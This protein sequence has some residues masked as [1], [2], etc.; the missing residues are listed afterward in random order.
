MNNPEPND[1]VPDSRPQ[2]PPATP[3]APPPPAV[4][5][6]P[7]AVPP[8]APAGDSDKHRL[9]KAEVAAAF[10]VSRRTVTNWLGRG[11]PSVR[12]PDGRRLFD[13]DEVRAWRLAQVGDDG[14]EDGEAAPASAASPARASLAKADLV[15]KVTQAK[16]S[17][18]EL[19]AEQA[20]KDLGL[21]TKILAAKTYEDYV[22]IDLEIGAL[23]ARGALS[24]ARARAIQAVI[25]DARQN[26]KA[27]REAEGDEEPQRL[28]LLTSEGAELVRAFEGICSDERRQGILDYVHA[29]AE[30]DLAEYPNVD[31]TR[32]AREEEGDPGQ[33][34]GEAGGA[35]PTRGP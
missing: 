8:P 13:R 10:G 30:V 11:C 6:P 15:R 24:P 9:T 4:P 22:A 31:M 20:L 33:D 16:K 26:T 1:H 27:H 5:P 29:E 7:P 14:E 34:G 17:E 35:E 21:D 3:P 32:A 18:L 19:A 28:I 2:D 12:G 25:A 23:L